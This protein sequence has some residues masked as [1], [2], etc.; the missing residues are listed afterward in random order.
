L[1]IWRWRRA[2]LPGLLSP[3]SRSFTWWRMTL[4][5]LRRWRVDALPCLPRKAHKPLA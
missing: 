4:G 5:R 3:L 1:K 2:K